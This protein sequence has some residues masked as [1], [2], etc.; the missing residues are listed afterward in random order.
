MKDPDILSVSNRYITWNGRTQKFF[1]VGSVTYSHLRLP[2]KK[3]GR[4]QICIAPFSYLGKRMSAVVGSV[5]ETET[6]ILQLWSKGLS[7]GTMS[8]PVSVGS[9]RWTST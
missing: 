1:T 5:F 2:L 8:P 6:P 4:H 9:N 3:N 7:F